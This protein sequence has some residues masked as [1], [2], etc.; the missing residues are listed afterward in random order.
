MTD[1]LYQLF[2]RQT[3][4]IL[5]RSRWLLIT[6]IFLAVVYS[7]IQ[8]THNYLLGIYADKAHQGPLY[9]FA[10]T[11]IYQG[12]MWRYFSSALWYAALVCMVFLFQLCVGGLRLND[13]LLASFGRRDIGLALWRLRSRLALRLIP[14][15]LGSLLIV[16]MAVITVLSLS[17]RQVDFGQA[18]T[19][20]VAPM[21]LGEQVMT[22]LASISLLTL[23]AVLQT[24]AASLWL[25]GRQ[26]S[27]VSI[28]VLALVLGLGLSSLL[29]IVYYRIWIEVYVLAGDFGWYYFKVLTMALYLSGAMFCWLAARRYSEPARLL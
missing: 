9:S 18:P 23:V 12:R 7:L 21:S 5:R 10:Q 20:W 19:F 17:G 28:S 15:L 1:P 14:G 3:R 29:S 27:L 4:T 22:L 11:W 24:L 13:D 25:R 6:G 8:V 2:L 26:V 16:Q